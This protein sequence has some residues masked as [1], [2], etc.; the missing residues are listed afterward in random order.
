MSKLFHSNSPNSLVRLETEDQQIHMHYQDCIGKQVLDLDEDPG[1][2]LEYVDMSDLICDEDNY[3]ILA[4]DQKMTNLKIIH[5]CY[6]LHLIYVKI[7]NYEPDIANLIRGM[8]VH[9]F[10][11]GNNLKLLK[12]AVAMYCDQRETAIDKYGHIG[13]WNVSKI[14]NFTSLFAGRSDFNDN[15][16][17]WDMS[18]AI[19]IKNMF[20]DAHSFNKPLDQWKLGNVTD[21]SGVFHNAVNFNQPIDKWDTSSCK[22]MTSMFENAEN[23]DQPIGDW[24]TS[25]VKQTKK[26][27]YNAKKFNQPIGNWDMSMVN[28]ATEMLYGAISFKQDVSGWTLSNI[29]NIRGI[30]VGTEITHRDAFYYKLCMTM[31][32]NNNYRSAIPVKGYLGHHYRVRDDELGHQKDL[33]NSEIRR[34]VPL[35]IY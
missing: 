33:V 27:F 16:N 18:N 31:H 30:F 25:N 19:N 8:V 15:I 22:T 21:M 9:Q 2:D 28:I 23:F 6:T 12:K 14:N 20:K 17:S 26:M 11:F 24:N 5:K 35:A 10:N 1:E 29:K 4:D 3:I 7:Y 13:Y 32:R 34:T